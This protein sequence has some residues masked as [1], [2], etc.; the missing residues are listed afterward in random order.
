MQPS[1]NTFS[2]QENSC[3]A[4]FTSNPFKNQALLNQNSYFKSA[5]PAWI[6]IIQMPQS[7]TCFLKKN[8]IIQMPQSFTC[9]LKKKLKFLLDKLLILFSKPYLGRFFL[10]FNVSNLEKPMRFRVKVHRPLFMM[11]GIKTPLYLWFFVNFF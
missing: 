5:T 6:L 10:V 7:F 4:K 3:L 9:F 1:Y 2:N 11:N 8:L